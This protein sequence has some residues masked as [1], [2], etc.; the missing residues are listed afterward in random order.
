VGADVSFLGQAEQQ[1]TIFKDSGTGKAGLEILKAHG[2]NW[3]RLR[4]FHTPVELPNNLDYTIALAKNVKRL[5]FKFLL[6]YHYADDWAD[7]GKQP[8]PNAWQGKSHAELVTAVFAY[9]RDTVFIPMGGPK[10]HENSKPAMCA[11]RLDKESIVSSGS[12]GEVGKLKA[13]LD[14]SRAASWVAQQD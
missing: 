10:A 11:N 13:R 5:G 9:T 2:Y 3:V 12:R 14:R 7:P 6:D 8:L 1:G 4:L